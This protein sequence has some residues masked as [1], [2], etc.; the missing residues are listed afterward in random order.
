MIIGWL[1][2]AWDW[3]IFFYLYDERR[4]GLG[5]NPGYFGICHSRI[6]GRSKFPKPMHEPTIIT[7]K[8]LFSLTQNT[9]PCQALCISQT[10][11]NMWRVTGKLQWSYRSCNGIWHVESSEVSAVNLSSLYV[12]LWSTYSI[13]GYYVPSTEP[14]SALDGNHP[15]ISTCDHIAPDY[16]GL[17][18]PVGNHDHQEP[19]KVHLLF[20]CEVWSSSRRSSWAA[21]SLTPS[22]IRLDLSARQ[23]G[24]LI[25]IFF[26]VLFVLDRPECS[27][28]DVLPVL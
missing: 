9:R 12:N 8:S 1:C 28:A 23:G 21:M 7:W 24:L 15:N 22:P 4:F 19:D 3:M 10:V 13:F 6:L 18:S 2:G 26:S 11:V 20:K 17:P 16:D 14:T 27:C 5:H 25:G